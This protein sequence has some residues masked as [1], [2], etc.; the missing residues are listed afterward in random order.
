[1]EVLKKTQKVQKNNAPFKTFKKY[2]FGINKQKKK[3]TKIEIHM[4]L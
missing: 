2:D 4:D 3:K 1:L